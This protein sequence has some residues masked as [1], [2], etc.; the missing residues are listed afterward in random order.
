MKYCDD[1][2]IDVGM[3]Y[4]NNTAFYLKKGFRVAAIEA[5]PL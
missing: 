4:G 5:N 3:H 1:L 2:I